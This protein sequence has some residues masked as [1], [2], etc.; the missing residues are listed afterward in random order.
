MSILDNL[1]LWG[2][3]IWLPWLMYFMIK[4]EAKP[5][6][7]IIV[8]TTLPY[9]AH[10]DA[11]VK[12][13]LAVFKKE[14]WLA[15]WLCMLPAVPGVLIHSFG[16][17]MT[18]WLTW[19]VVV[20]FV[21]MIPYVRCNRSLRALKEVRGWKRESS[22]RAV[23]DLKVVAAEMK[24][25]SPVLFV[26][27]VLISL[28]PMLFDREL[29]VVWL[30]MAAMVGVFYF[31]YRYLYRNR[32]EMVDSN[33]ERTMEL[34]RIR[35]YYWGK[36]WLIMAWA[37]GVLNPL[38][39]LTMYHFWWSTA[40][41]VAY[42]AVVMWTMLSIEFRVRAQQ[43][44][45]CKDSGRED[46]IDEDENWIWGMFYYNPHDKRLVVNARVGI[47]S[48]VNLAKR[49][50]QIIAGLTMVLL[51]ACPVMGIWMMDMENASVEL[52]VTDTEVVATH[53]WSEY[54]VALED[55]EAVHQLEKLPPTR[56]VSG[57]GLP[58]VSTGTWTCEGWGRVTCC[59][60]P[61]IGP[62]LVIEAEDGKNY[63]FNSTDS[64]QTLAVWEQIQSA[65][66]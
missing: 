52:T 35:R 59:I 22:A 60:D 24:W 49:S 20:C 3:C 1:M 12:K 56:R 61:R 50:G 36:S 27:P 62:W 32:A 21:P 13:I 47:N 38:I 26:P 8:G 31:C 40:V 64:G 53:Y 29:W 41:F 42:M 11:E 43:E 46:Y 33:T 19:I 4:N 34:T 37:T 51:L 44:K 30:S 63:L 9:E 45:L 15:T 7:N 58:Y 25:L 17:S 55:I 39:W 57:T 28:I 14:L 5:K 54:S 6:K 10:G 18:V 65:A 66:S 2:S 16:V 23:A 48:T